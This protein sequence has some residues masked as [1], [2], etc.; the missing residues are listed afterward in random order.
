M[1][2]EDA[3][4][5]I[6]TAITGEGPQRW[7]D[8]GSGKGTFTH[9]LQN[10]LPHGSQITPID[11]LPQNL[12]NFTRADFEHDDLPLA[13]L[14]G[15]LLANSLH[16][17][18]DKIKLIHKLETYFAAEPTFLII[19][20]DTNQANT[21]VPYPIPYLELEKLFQNMGYQNI[22]KL[23]QR[24]SIYNRADLYSAFIKK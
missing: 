21:W 17:I 13:D 5:L 8:L 1:K 9:A 10:L 4:A 14:D 19:E 18:Q 20:Y 11:K 15:I 23:A 6:Q 16:Y 3:I 24:R 7:A 22:H 12:P 2:Q